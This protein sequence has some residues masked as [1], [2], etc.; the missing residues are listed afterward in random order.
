VLARF[1]SA[2]EICRLAYSTAGTAAG[3]PEIKAD[4][5][6]VP[7]VPI[8]AANVEPKVQ[9]KPLDNILRKAHRFAA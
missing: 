1:I 6:P 2:P 9:V 3:V 4:P 7:Q 8:A 5:E